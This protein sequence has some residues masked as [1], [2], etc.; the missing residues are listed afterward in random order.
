MSVVV[1]STVAADEFVNAARANRTGC[2]AFGLMPRMFTLVSE[3]GIRVS[4]TTT[5]TMAM[6][7]SVMTVPMNGHRNGFGL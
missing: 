5:N 6:R 4:A 3:S 1:V 2:V 7:R